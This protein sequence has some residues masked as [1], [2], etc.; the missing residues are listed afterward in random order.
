M[1]GFEPTISRWQREVL[2]LYYTS[3]GTGPRIRTQIVLFWRQLCCRYTRPIFILI[4]WF[5]R[6]QKYLRIPEQRLSMYYAMD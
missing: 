2:P 3:I 1:D 5:L 6:L 4:V